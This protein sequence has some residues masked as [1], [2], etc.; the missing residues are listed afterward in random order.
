MNFVHELFEQKKLSRINENGTRLYVTESGNKYPSVTSALSYFSRKGIQ[1]WR[2]R[3]GSEEAN[4]ISSQAAR[5]GTAVHNIAE[6]YVSNDPSWKKAMPTSI[7]QFVKIKPMLDSN[8]DKIHGI[9]LQMW[10]E[11]FRV[12]GTADLICSYNG[13]N[14]LLD[15][16]TSRRVKTKDQ[17]LSYFLQACA[18]S[19]MA[20][21]LYDFDVEQTVILMTVANGPAIEFVEAI[22]TYMPMASKFFQLYSEGKLR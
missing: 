6:K 15:F 3:V 22:D 19:Q 18:Y 1:Q 9:E 10:S 4:R 12:A 8:I 11:K 17:I 2:Q 20:K 14:T 21:E 5:N 7:E 16:K 13:K